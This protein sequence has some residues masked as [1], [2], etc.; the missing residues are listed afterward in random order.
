MNVLEIKMGNGLLRWLVLGASVCSA[1]RDN[2][3]LAY[4][5]SRTLE[6]KIRAYTDSDKGR[7]DHRKVLTVNS[8]TT[9]D[10]VRFEMYNTYPDSTGAQ[11]LGYVRWS[12]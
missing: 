9:G 5:P 3:R 7:T 12:D 8:L 6:G 4:Y 2:T 1:C 10:T 11:L